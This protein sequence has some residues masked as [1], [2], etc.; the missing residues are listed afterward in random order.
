M[1]FGFAIYTYRRVKDLS[2]E[3]KARQI[4]EIEALKLTRRDP[5]TGL[6][7]RRSFVEKLNQVLSK[8]KADSRA[9]VLMLD[10][11]GFRSINS[12]YGRAAGDQALTVFSE[13]LSAVARSG[14]FLTRI[15]G[16]EFAIMMPEINSLDDP[17]ALARRVWRPSRNRS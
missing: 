8:T 9:A 16:D 13:L 4:A 1:S 12:A 17:A 7:N 11:D 2:H 6:P 14:T 3:M 10:L 15:G 5:L